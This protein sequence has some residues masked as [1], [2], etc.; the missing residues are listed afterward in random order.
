[1]DKTAASYSCKP[2]SIY[3]DNCLDDQRTVRNSQKIEGDISRIQMYQGM[4]IDTS[5]TGFTIWTNKGK[6]YDLGNVDAYPL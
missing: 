3:G 4:S 2:L 6:K 5:P 1:M